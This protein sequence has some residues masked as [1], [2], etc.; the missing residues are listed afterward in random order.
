VPG[1]IAIIYKE[2]KYGE[3]LSRFLQLKKVPVYSKR[4]TDLFD[5]P[6]AQ[7]ILL[8]LRYLAAE[9]DAPYGGDEMLFEILHF[10]FF[11]IAPI[12]IAKLSVEVADKQFSEQKT[13]IRRLLFEKASRP[14]RDL[15][16]TGLPEGLKKASRALKN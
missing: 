8:L 15:F 5:I 7:K 6:L 14:A 13:S 12:E 16:D 4:S 9:H 2:N 3:E 1:R 11:S 10:D